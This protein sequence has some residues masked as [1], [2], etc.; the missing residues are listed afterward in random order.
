MYKIEV[1]KAVEQAEAYLGKDEKFRDSVY[2]KQYPVILK[3][4]ASFGE[5]SCDNF[6]PLGLM[7]YGWMPTAYDSC[8]FKAIESA[9]EALNKARG[10]ET[11]KND[12]L[13]N[14]C[15]AINN[16]YVGA[17]KLLHFLCPDTYAIWDS[18]VARALG[19]ESYASVNKLSNY[20]HYCPDSS[21]LPDTGV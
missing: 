10:G 5:I 8:D 2:L 21:K 18:R 3:H 4:V 19:V 1:A 17:S 7:T 15:S 6:I 11:L 16:S 13:E 12:D 9:I 20:K 14:L